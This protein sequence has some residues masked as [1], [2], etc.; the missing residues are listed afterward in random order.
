M[1]ITETKVTYLS[2][3]KIE[4]GFLVFHQDLKEMSKFDTS[5]V[6]SI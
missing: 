1:M 3:V 6:H 5:F 2:N 4:G